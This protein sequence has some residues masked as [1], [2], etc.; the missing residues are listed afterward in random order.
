MSLG[1]KLSDYSTFYIVLPFDLKV[2]T[3]NYLNVGHDGSQTQF[4][5]IK[6]PCSLET[7]DICPIYQ[8]Q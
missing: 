8:G 4:Y 6:K 1:I 7:T 2:V 3:L 5:L